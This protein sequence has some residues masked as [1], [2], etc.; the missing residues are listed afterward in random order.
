MIQLLYDYGS[1]PTILN[2]NNQS[3]LHIACASN[4]LSIIKEL[5]HLT[6]SS[7]LEIKDRLGRTALSVTTQPDIIEYLIKFGA[8]ISSVD[9]NHMNAI[10]IAVSTGQLNTVKCLLSIIDFR[11]VSI[12]DQVEEKHQRS[13]FLIAIQ[14]GS[15]DLCSLLLT[16]PSIRWDTA[17]KQHRNA[18]HIA[19]QNNHSEL[20]SLL[21]NHIQQTAKLQTMKSRCNSITP[22]I[23]SERLNN[24]QISSTLRLY[25]DAQ[26]E[27]GKTPLHLASEQGHIACVE[28][29]VN[30]GADFFLVNYLGQLPLH[31]AIQNGHSQ[32][33]DILLKACTKNMSQFQSILSRRQL[34]IIS[35]CR[36]G[37]IDIVKLLISQNIGVDFDTD[38]DHDNDE[39]PLE[40]AIKYRQSETVNILLEDSNSEQW[41]TPVRKSNKYN[42]QTPL[43]DLIRYMPHCAQHA[44]NNLIVKKDETDLFGKTY[45]RTIYKYK[46]IDD[47]FM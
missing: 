3:P 30:H 14:T 24:P 35:A 22:V 46:Y 9:N 47:Y 45:E 28:I 13:L 20:I 27:D 2:S 1:D 15:A 8:D 39:N 25:I 41:L 17:D 10:M 31:A 44:F 37:F 43:R 42:H 23:S 34:P 5:C 11:L 18:F 40:I 6:Q 21:I 12:F 33:V 29:L 26:D 36:Y 38:V 19:A 16:Y 7:L 32:C 4:R